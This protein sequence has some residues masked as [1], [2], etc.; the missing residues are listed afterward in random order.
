MH[1][2][3]PNT[4][5]SFLQ[6][7]PC[8]SLDCTH[9]SLQL[10][11]FPEYHC[12]GWFPS[13]PRSTQNFVSV[14]KLSALPWAGPWEKHTLGFSDG[15]KNLFSFTQ[16]YAIL[17]PKVPWAT[18]SFPGGLLDFRAYFLPEANTL[19]RLGKW[20][21]IFIILLTKLF[22]MLLYTPALDFYLFGIDHV[23]VPLKYNSPIKLFWHTLDKV[24]ACLAL[25]CIVAIET[26]IPKLQKF[27]EDL[28]I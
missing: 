1:Q 6:D 18:P 16:S 28:K 25:V 23:I 21:R 19:L 4:N 24:L 10:S 3:H 7:P 2:L 26:L 5:V 11:I 20:E 9:V 15:D 14:R 8:K 13:P 22:Y 17:L 27:C 12:I